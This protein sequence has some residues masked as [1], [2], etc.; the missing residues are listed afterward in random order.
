MH[1]M[2]KRVAYN[3]QVIF[4]S[5]VLAIIL[6]ICN[7]YIGKE[8]FFLLL[9]FDGGIIADYF[10]KYITY[11][12]DGLVWLPVCIYLWIKHRTY[13]LTA[14]LSFSFS[15]II[16]QFFKYI[17]LP[18]E[19]RPTLAIR[20]TTLIHTIQNVRLHDIGSFPSGHTAT[21]FTVM[22]LFASIIEHKWLRLFLLIL[23]CCVAY[24]RIY[25]AQHFPLDIAGGIMTAIIATTVA[26]VL[27][28]YILSKNQKRN[29]YK[30]R[31]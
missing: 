26:C 19:P 13:F 8:N 23:A 21:A 6:F 1:K 20:N 3:L 29:M 27:S 30:L 24:S 2:K 10:F 16:A 31:V 22:F 12:G 25:L 4:P 11:V 7:F 28:T 15:T 14:V 17:I 5:T 18:V 9:N